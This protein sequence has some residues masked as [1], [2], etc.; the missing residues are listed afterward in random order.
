[1]RFCEIFIWKTESGESRKVCHSFQF[2]FRFQFKLSSILSYFILEWI[3]MQSLLVSFTT[4]LLNAHKKEF[5]IE[6]E[7]AKLLVWSPLKYEGS[8]IVTILILTSRW[9]IYVFLP[10]FYREKKSNNW[11]RLK[12]ENTCSPM[13]KNENFVISQ[14]LFSFE[15]CSRFSTIQ[16]PVW[17]TSEI[18]YIISI[19]IF[20]S[21]MRDKVFFL[22]IQFLASFTFRVLTSS[23]T[24]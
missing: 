15:F 19:F 12:F 7:I 4:L 6:M 10:N 16:I 22:L 9:N 2:H 17:N 24:F 21:L 13:I 18:S 20:Y 11:K 3:C 14:H 23:L 5:K 1:M 8:E